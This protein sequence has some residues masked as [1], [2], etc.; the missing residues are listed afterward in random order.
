[1]GFRFT[2]QFS[3]DCRVTLN[4]HSFVLLQQNKSFPGKI[5]RSCDGDDMDLLAALQSTITPSNEVF[6]SH[7]RI[8]APFPLETP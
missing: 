1:L 3:C 6:A 5:L 4:V 2:N 7:I 8:L